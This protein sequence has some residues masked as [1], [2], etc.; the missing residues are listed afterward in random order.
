VWKSIKKKGELQIV[1]AKIKRGNGKN[2]KLLQMQADF[3]EHQ[4]LKY[5]KEVKKVRAGFQPRLN[6]CKDEEI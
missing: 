2:E 3:E 6:F 4:S 1:C 5:Y